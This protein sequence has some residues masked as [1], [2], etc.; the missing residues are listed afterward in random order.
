MSLSDLAARLN[1]TSSELFRMLVV[2]ERRAYVTRDPASGNYSLSLRLYEIAHTHTPVDHLLR[3]AGLPMR[4]LSEEVRESCHLSMLRR[5]H[6]VILFHTESP[7]KIRLSIE[8]GARFSAIRSNSGRLLLA[9][10]DAA[11]LSEYFDND[12]EAGQISAREKARL[13]AQLGE[14]RQSGYLIS[15]SETRP[16]MKDISVPVGNPQLNIMAALCIP[17]LLGGRDEAGQRRILRALQNCAERI[18]EGLGLSEG[19]REYPRR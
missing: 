17:C 5:D 9:F 4:Q 2:L 16:G 8:V 3:A 6:L 15:D 19:L 14:I 7:E 1:R 10:L 18:R 12:S 11:E 13:I